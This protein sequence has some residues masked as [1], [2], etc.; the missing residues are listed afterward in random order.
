MPRPIF[1]P[2]VHQPHRLQIC[3]LLAP[4]R[5]LPFAEVRDEIGLS[6]S[7]LSK[8]LR[9]LEAE[10][11]VTVGRELTDGRRTTRVTLTPA[12]REALCGHV[13]ELQRLARLAS[14]RPRV[15]TA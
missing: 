15:R 13:S 4:T 3:A 10:G 7:A 6:D 8:H 1:D 11:Y 2:V 12:G 14:P 9:S 5:G